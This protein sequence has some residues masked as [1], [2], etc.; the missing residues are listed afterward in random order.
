MVKRLMKIYENDIWQRDVDMVIESLPEM[1]ELEGKAVLITGCTGLVGAAIVNVFIRWNITHV[2]KIRIVAAGRNV[3]KI[4]EL[5]EEYINETWFLVEFYE[6]TSNH[7]LFKTKCDYIIH[8][9]S[10]SSPDKI[11]SEPVE[12]MLA[13]IVGLNSLFEYAKK[14]HSKRLL[15]IS[16]SEVYGSKNDSKSFGINDY[17]YIDLL[18]IRSSY[19]VSKR[20]AETFSISY[21]KEYEIDSVI[22]RPGHI[23]G[24]TAKLTDNRVSSK[25]LYDSLKGM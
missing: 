5:F 11:V 16:S 6:A 4:N 19:S 24:P 7:V 3:K 9:A 12:T 10:N 1:S 14:Y 13:N 22:A 21:S 15:L 17:G 20:A 25:W 8:G 23:Y 18:D 2:N